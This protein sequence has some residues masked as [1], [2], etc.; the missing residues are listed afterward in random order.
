MEKQPRIGIITQ[1]RFGSTRLPGKVLREVS[2]GETLLDV[3]LE[4]VAK[5]KQ[6]HCFIVATTEEEQSKDTPR[7]DYIYEPDDSRVLLDGLM[8]RYIESLLY[9]SVI[10]NGACEQAAKMVAMKNAT[11]NAGKLIDEL[12]LIYN[13]ARQAAITQEIAEIVGGAAAV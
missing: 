6:A 12:Q 8:E 11:E 5:T 3:H 13:N 10:E 2:P 4:R 9:Q 1:A 7:W